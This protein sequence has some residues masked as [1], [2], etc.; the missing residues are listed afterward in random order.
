MC[1]VVCVVRL[2]VKGV[3]VDGELEDS[4]P[5]RLSAR[6]VF[7]FWAKESGMIQSVE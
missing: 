3:K 6:G 2:M 4:D 5:V 1:S 7:P